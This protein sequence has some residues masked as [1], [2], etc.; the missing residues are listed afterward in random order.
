MRHS[1]SMARKTMLKKAMDKKHE[2]FS[3]LLK[4][5]FNRF[6]LFAPGIPLR[7]M[8]GYFHASPSGTCILVNAYEAS[9]QF[10]CPNDN[11]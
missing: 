4:P 7:F 8:P 1:P 2:F 5:D 11:F 10:V 9:S 6:C 3:G